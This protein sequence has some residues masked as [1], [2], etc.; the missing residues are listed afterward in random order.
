MTENTGSGAVVTTVPEIL[1]SSFRCLKHPS[2]LQVFHALCSQEQSTTKDIEVSTNLSL[3]V[4]NQALREMEEL[5]L[6]RQIGQSQPV[7]SKARGKVRAGDWDEKFNLYSATPHGKIIHSFVA[8]Y[9]PEKPVSNLGGILDPKDVV[10]SFATLGK[11]E[12]NLLLTKFRDLYLLAGTLVSLHY[13]KQESAASHWL[14]ACLRGKLM[15]DEVESFLSNYAGPEGLVV[16]QPIQR[17]FLERA[18]IRFAKLVAGKERVAKLLSKA[19]YSLTTRGANIANTLAEQ[20]AP[21]DLG[22]NE[23]FLRPEKIEAEHGELGRA[24]IIRL[25][26]ASGLIGLTVYSYWDLFRVARYAP[27]N[28]LELVA[29]VVAAMI[30]S[31]GSVF[32]ATMRLPNL[33]IRISY[34]ISLRRLTRKTDIG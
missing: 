1:Y 6:A 31:M 28:T 18:I 9:N 3:K 24:I 27:L 15:G 33:L 10:E 21:T 2:K 14:S 17:N 19:S 29:D 30:G 5:N 8:N 25:L 12:V 23:N 20:F 11:E 22:V 32:W 34:W 16:T 7:T 26:V 4:V 13:Q